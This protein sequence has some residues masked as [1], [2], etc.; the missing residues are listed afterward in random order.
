MVELDGFL[1]AH[2]RSRKAEPFA[3][4]DL[5]ALAKHKTPPEI[6]EFLREEGRAGYR[7]DFFV[8]TLP[9][10]HF[11]ALSEWGLKGEQC[12]TFLRTAFGSLCFAMKGKIFQLEPLS[13]YLYK[14][15]FGFAD[16]MNVLAPMDAFLEGCW[17]DRYAQIKRRKKLGPDEIY[18]LSPALPLGGSFEGS[19]LEVVK[20]REHLAMLAELF[21][22]KA[23]KM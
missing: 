6:A 11:A 19:K 7:D 10:D 23:R 16:F 2:P 3:A 22:H 14:G 8:S 21:G 15:R 9:Q 18:G 1:E 20:L 4:A 17:F 5:A 13:G 12:H